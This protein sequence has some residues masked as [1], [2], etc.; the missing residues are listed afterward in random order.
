M[1]YVNSYKNK[2]GCR[3]AQMKRQGVVEVPL[4]SGI[5][6]FGAEYLENEIF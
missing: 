2:I 6:H 1:V 5:F 3:N 4:F